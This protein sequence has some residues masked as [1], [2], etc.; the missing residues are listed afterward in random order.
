MST[1]QKMATSRE[2]VGSGTLPC[3]RALVL[4]CVPTGVNSVECQGVAV[5]NRKGGVRIGVEG[6]DVRTSLGP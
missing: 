5:V 4:L 2:A 3:T 6:G 1:A